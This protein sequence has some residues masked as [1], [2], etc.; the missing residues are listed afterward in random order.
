MKKYCSLI[1]AFIIIACSSDPEPLSSINQTTIDSTAETSIDTTYKVIENDSLQIG[2]C[3]FLISESPDTTLFQ[4]I[5]P[6][7]QGNEAE[8]LPIDKQVKRIGDSLIFNLSNGKELIIVDNPFDQESNN[9][10]AALYTFN[11]SIGASNY[12]ELNAL[13]YEYHWYTII[14]K[15]NGEMRLTSGK[16]A[17]SP[18]GKTLLCVNGDLD[19]Q[20]TVNGLELFKVGQDSIE[21]IGE[22]ELETWGPYAVKWLNNS[23][24]LITKGIMGNELNHYNM[25]YSN[26]LL[27]LD[28]ASI[29]FLNQPEIGTG[30]VKIIFDAETKLDFYA[31]KTDDN[32]IKSIE[33]FDDTAINSWSIRNLKQEQKWLQPESLWLDYHQFNFRCIN[34]SKGWFEI[35]VNHQTG[36]TYW[37]RESNETQYISWENNLK[38]MFS[39]VRLTEYPQSIK[40]EPTDAATEIEYEGDDCFIVKAMK[41][42]W[43]EIATADYCED[44]YTDS[45]T[46]INSGWIKWKSGNTF[47][48][49]YF[50]TA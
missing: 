19:V 27:T 12:W 11:G 41:D 18:N 40:T 6:F 48:I 20:Y 26:V 46:P 31:K 17:L 1:I 29:A 10:D 36:K 35:L 16:P 8:T 24:I 44:G 21:L 39:V 30:L 49:E 34:Q 43:I 37:L 32:P 50:P 4:G 3:T 22:N 15:T 45:K 42:D 47:L 14:N 25:Q 7:Q 38:N 28:S 2:A 13:G 33:F 9:L 23:E 5:D